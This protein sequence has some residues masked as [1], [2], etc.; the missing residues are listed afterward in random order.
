MNTDTLAINT[1][2]FRPGYFLLLILLISFPA[3]AEEFKDPATFTGEEY[4]MV[5]AAGADYNTCLREESLKR[6]E[7]SSDPRRLADAAMKSC[8]SILEQLYTEITHKNYSPEVARRFSWNISNRGANK[9]LS[10]LMRYM[11][12]RNAAPPEPAQSAPAAGE[13][14]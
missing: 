10:N 3:T 4:Q 12:T 13:Q 5:Q 7:Q 11:A 9:L 14:E 8:A 1:M 2:K 6:I